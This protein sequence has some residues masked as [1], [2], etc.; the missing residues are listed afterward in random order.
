VKLTVAGDAPCNGKLALRIPGWCR[1]HALRLNGAPLAAEVKDG[2]AIVQREWRDGDRLVLALDMPVTLV[3][4]N[5]RIYE[6]AGKV[7][8]QRGPL[9]YCLEEAD[10]SRNLHAVRLGGA[11]AGSFTTQWKP[12]KLGGIVELQSPGLRETD[13]G[14]GET[15]Y[16]AVQQIR[17]VPAR[18]TWIPYYSWANRT[19]GEM[20]VWVRE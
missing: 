11:E 18:L 20:R 8:V 9:V 5:P 2:Y 4:A 3:R 15:P 10:N 14:W 13:E 17:T 1:S 6:D 7:A 19:P 12:E 16:S